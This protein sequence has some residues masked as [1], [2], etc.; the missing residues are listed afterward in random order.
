MSP[1]M[2][3]LCAASLA[4]AC[5]PAEYTPADDFPDRL[6]K[7]CNSLDECRK[8]VDA[9]IAR[10]ERCQEQDIGVTRSWARCTD[11]CN[12][13]VV[14]RDKAHEWAIRQARAVGSEANP[15]PY[16]RPVCP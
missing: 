9:G 6:K 1:R 8:L 16:L 13:M 10:F 5:D 12:D 7:G 3:A 14:A 4:L 15:D 2:S 11:A